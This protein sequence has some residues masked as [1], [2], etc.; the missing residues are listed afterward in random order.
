MDNTKKKKLGDKEAPKP[1]MQA[2]KA[3]LTASRP[4][5]HLHLCRWTEKEAA[6]GT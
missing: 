5:G 1:K 2:G 6:T 4:A 3:R